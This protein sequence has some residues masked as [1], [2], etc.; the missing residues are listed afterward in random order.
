MFDAFNVAYDEV[1]SNLR[2]DASEDEGAFGAFDA[3]HK[4]LQGERVPAPWV[5]GPGVVVNRVLRMS[6]VLTEEMPEACG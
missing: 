1:R 2:W 3:M 4:M 6:S 5:G